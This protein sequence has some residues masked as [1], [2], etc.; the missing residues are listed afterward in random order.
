MSTYTQEW[1]CCGSTSTTE[2][3]EPEQYPFCEV[4]CLT[5]PGDI[6]GLL[7]RGSP[8]LH[9]EVGH[10]DVVMFISDDSSDETAYVAESGQDDGGA[11]G[12]WEDCGDLL[13]DLSDPTGRAHAAWWLMARHTGTKVATHSSWGP[14]KSWQRIYKPTLHTGDGMSLYTD[15]VDELCPDL[16]WRDPR[17]LADGSKWVYAEALRRVVLHVAGR[18]VTP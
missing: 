13:L 16:D 4:D 1:D 11:R 10:E 3:W 12:G 14:Y 7:R 5:L 2:A 18:E 8:V 6:P 9:K 15:K 17:T